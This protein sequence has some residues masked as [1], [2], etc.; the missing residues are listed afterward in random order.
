MSDSSPTSFISQDDVRRMAA[1]ARL[2]VDTSTQER[3]TRQFADILAYMDVLAQV[4]TLGVEPL[5]SPALHE[6]LPRPDEARSH[7]T[8][9]EVLSNAPEARLH[10]DCPFFVV[11]RIV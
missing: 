4:D 1:L 5:Y 6:G 2:D 11:P 8:T 9:D 10:D 7:R 3:F